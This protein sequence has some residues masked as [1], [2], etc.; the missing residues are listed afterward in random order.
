MQACTYNQSVH[1]CTPAYM[2]AHAECTCMHA[3]IH[4]LIM[5]NAYS[6]SLLSA[7]SP[8][9]DY[10]LERLHLFSTPQKRSNTP[11]RQS[12]V[13]DVLDRSRHR[14]SSAV[15]CCI[16]ARPTPNTI[17][18]GLHGCAPPTAEASMPVTI[19][20]QKNSRVYCGFQ[21]TQTGGQSAAL[22]QACK[23]I[24]DPVIVA[25]ACKGFS[26]P[27][28]TAAL[29]RA[30]K[31]VGAPVT[32]ATARLVL[33]SRENKSYSARSWRQRRP[34]TACQGCSLPRKTAALLRPVAE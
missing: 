32:A 14:F 30:G 24:G 22:A 6:L 33:T 13:S 10:Q 28:K 23:G 16:I 9:R 20:K 11:L 3:C 27:H 21:H 15:A 1:A 2:Y 7:R 34:A 31:V 18:L 29:L 26:L 12:E 19:S 5:Y 4:A 8:S 25:T 17:A